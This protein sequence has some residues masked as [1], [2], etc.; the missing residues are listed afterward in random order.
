MPTNA[1]TET[2]NITIV[3]VLLFFASHTPAVQTYP[4]PQ[5]TSNAHVEQS[6]PSSTISLP[7]TAFVVCSPRIDATSVSSNSPSPTTTVHACVVSDV[8]SFTTTLTVK[9]PSSSGV[10]VNVSPVVCT[11]SST[12]HVMVMVSPSASDTETENSWLFPGSIVGFDSGLFVVIVGAAFPE[13]TVIVN[14]LVVL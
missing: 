3:F 2:R 10:N 5:G 1:T 11:S 13:P 6:S 9:T 8:P 7:Q 12:D 4:S 14:V